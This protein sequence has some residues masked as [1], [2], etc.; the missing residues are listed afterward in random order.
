VPKAV[1]KKS[2]TKI[3][4][5]KKGVR[6]ITTNDAGIFNIDESIKKKDKRV[7]AWEN[8]KLELPGYGTISTDIRPRF[9]DWGF[10]QYVEAFKKDKSL[11]FIDPMSAHEDETYMMRDD[12]NLPTEIAEL[13]MDG[14]RGL[15]YIGEDAN[16]SFSRRISKATGWYSENSDQVPHIRDLVM[17]DLSGTVIDGEFDFGTDSM[18]VQS[19]MGALPANAI[20]YQVDNKW[21][22]F[23]AFDILYY[24]GMNIQAMPLWKRKIYLHRVIREF[25]KTYGKSPVKFCEFFVHDKAI[26]EL[27]N[28]LREY[29]TRQEIEELMERVDIVTSYQD[30]FRK[31]ESIGKEGII[32]KDMH[33]R[34]EQKKSKSFI[35]VKAQSTW[36]VVMIGITE[37][38]KYYDGKLT[39][40]ALS[41]W[42]YWI[43]EDGEDIAVT[44]P[45][46]MGWCGGIEFGV[47]KK[48]TE[49]QYME[50]MNTGLDEQIM[51]EGGCYIDGDLYQMIHVGDCKGLSD[52]IM[53]DLKENYEE[54]IRE[55]RVFEVKAN[56][57]INKET[58][59]LRHP[60]FGKWR[61]DKSSDQ[62][63]F[64]DHIREV[65]K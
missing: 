43:H 41:Q 33:A 24:K 64:T 5:V 25:E 6:L 2:K 49:L 31:L 4:E 53:Q 23:F 20:Q 7:L 59:S 48:L 44:K 42:D 62:C 26:R 37:P 16:R 17:P 65:E 57:I 63:T 30:T 1:K 13:K 22:D 3:K 14:H 46:F 38:T 40:E 36:D 10:T 50:V 58:G 56:G 19:V 28:T 18:G 21:I 60:R 34:Y 54:Y 12:L 52:S 47:L 45:Y 39:G 27:E 8:C 61:D 29:T 15:V 11:R 32:V 9:K 51:D 35:K 55:Q